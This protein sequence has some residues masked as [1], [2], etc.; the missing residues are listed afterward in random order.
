[1]LKQSKYHNHEVLSTLEQGRTFSHKKMFHITNDF[2]KSLLCKSGHWLHVLTPVFL[3][4]SMPVSLRA[5][6]CISMVVRE[7]ATALPPPETLTYIA[8][9][10]GA[11]GR[12]TLKAHPRSKSR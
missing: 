11:T 10:E 1:M 9:R 5:M 3:L 8:R 4:A 7:L 12:K 2:V 6:P